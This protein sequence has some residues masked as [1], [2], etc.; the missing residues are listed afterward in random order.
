MHGAA[1]LTLA[2]SFFI[3]FFIWFE[4]I[5]EVIKICLDVSR[6][7]HLPIKL[8][9]WSHTPLFGY[10]YHWP[11]FIASNIYVQWDVQFTVMLIQYT[12]TDTRKTA[13]TFFVFV[14]NAW[15]SSINMNN[16]NS[17]EIKLNN[18]HWIA[19]ES[20]SD[21]MMI[22]SCS[23]ENDAQKKIWSVLPSKQ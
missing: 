9:Y 3:S 20:N 22:H 19:I 7:C 18:P 1:I 2:I 12:Y 15:R 10:E 17:D 8:N 16:N 11:H 21:K 14:M 23:L 5:F 13:D 6:R 4:N